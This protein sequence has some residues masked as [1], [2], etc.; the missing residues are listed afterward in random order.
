MN[1]PKFK[2]LISL[3]PNC[4]YTWI[5]LEYSGLEW[6]DEREKPTEAEIDAEVVRME[7]EW[8]ALQYQRDRQEIYPSLEDVIVALAERTEGNSQMWDK[9][10]ALRLEVKS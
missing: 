10:T 7:V 5:G 8:D 2:A 6:S 3:V 4:D 1:I 9:I